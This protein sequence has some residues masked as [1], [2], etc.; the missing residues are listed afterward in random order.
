M[1][2]CCFTPYGFVPAGL[3]EIR[4][5]FLK[6]EPV[7]SAVDT[8]RNVKQFYGNHNLLT[9]YRFAGCTPKI[10]EGEKFKEYRR[11]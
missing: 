11:K 3:A 1:T 9:K 4:T 8:V 2:G 10:K 7:I 5:G 6:Q